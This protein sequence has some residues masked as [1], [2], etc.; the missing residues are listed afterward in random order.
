VDGGA[1]EGED[2]GDDQ[3]DVH[4]EPSATGAI[5]RRKSGRSHALKTFMTNSADP[6]LE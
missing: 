5:P 6:G 4:A 3:R 2:S 1:E